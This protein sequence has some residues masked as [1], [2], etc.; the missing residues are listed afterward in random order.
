[1]KL[2]AVTSRFPYGPKEAFLT[3]EIERFAERFD[4]LVLPA[5]PTGQPISVPS[6]DA[7]SIRLPL[8]SRPVLRLAAREFARDPLRALR[9]FARVVSSPRSL[10]AKIKNAAIFPTA[11]AAAR[12]AR[13]RS[14]DRVHAYWLTTP[15]TIAFVV[16][17]LNRI[18]WSA[19]GHRHDL[20]DFNVTTGDG[21]NAGF[22]PTASFVRTISEQG[23]D[24]LTAAFSGSRPPVH[25]VHLGVRV[26]PPCPRATSVA[27]L[28]LIC[29]AN[30]EAVKGH[31]TLLEAL[32]LA[33]ERCDVHCTFY[34]DGTL[35][36]EL[37][38]LADR[39]HLHDAVHF[40]G[41]IA[42]DRLLA[43]MESNEF[44]AAIL[45]SVDDGPDRREGI[46]VFLME[47][48]ARNLPVI[49]TRSG[50][51]AE[52]TGTHAALLCPAGDA[53][54]IADAVVTFA[55]DAAARERFAA[56]GRARVE[57]AFDVT[58]NARVIAALICGDV[59]AGPERTPMEI[60]P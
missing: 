59:T 20:V 21:R 18:P 37:E 45:T 16:S 17:Q 24:S 27:R 44:D 35:R 52:L 39:L 36:E 8:L 3:A 2:L 29:A 7:R 49:A 4:V 10:H 15:A 11:L 12:I 56:L 58:K 31:R 9:V 13:E 42:H 55:N 51:V 38:L 48:M 57:N 14:I 40:A 46:P 19:T 28:R 32:A 25:V 60:H 26:P 54:A 30:L 23:A 47:A 1:M 22:F 33:V 53:T 50:A 34:G 41:V 43:K 6:L 5:L